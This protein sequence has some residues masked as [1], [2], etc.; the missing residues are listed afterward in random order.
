M[1]RLTSALAFLWAVPAA[2]RQSPR[3]RASSVSLCCTRVQ[4]EDDSADE[5]ARPRQITSEEADWSFVADGRDWA[6]VESVLLAA[7]SAGRPALPGDESAW[8]PPRLPTFCEPSTA[9]GVPKSRTTWACS[10]A[11]YGPS[12]RGYAWQAHEPERTVQGL[13]EEAIKPL[14]L[15]RHALVLNCAGRTDA[16]VS[17][18]GQLVS[19]YSWA[20]IEPEQLRA[21]IDS[22]APAKLRLLSAA[23][24]PRA[25]HA[26]FCAQWRR[27]VYLLPLRSADCSPLHAFEDLSAEA[28]NA[29]LA[30]LV[31]VELDYSALGRGVPKGKNTRAT[32]HR[33]VARRVRLSAAQGGVGGRPVGAAGGGQAVEALRIDVVADRF[34]R[35]QVRTLVATAVL[36]ARD[37]PPDEPH[38]LLRR[39][40]SGRQAETA[41]AAPAV[42]L[43]FAE[44]GYAP[45]ASDE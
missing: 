24:V 42:G 10:I 25:F 21:A 38:A 20:N 29:Q 31:G 28:L 37:A 27:Y 3:I 36:A 19:F 4:Q 33:A 32:L 16:G 44:A 1:L 11:Y 22:C 8:A 13:L 40:C 45:W 39:V 7:V 12:F 2:V 26:T 23:R 17:A 9:A 35:R 14:L 18:V 30:P 6:A 5:G 41:V 34:L 15:G 43:C